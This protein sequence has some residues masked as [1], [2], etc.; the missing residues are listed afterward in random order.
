MNLIGRAFQFLQVA[1]GRVFAK[2]AHYAERYGARGRSQSLDFRRNAKTIF[3]GELPKKYQGLVDLIPGDRVVEVG[4]G[5]GVLSMELSAHKKA[6][7]AIDYTPMRHTKGQ[8][9]KAAWEAL[10][11]DVSRCELVLGDVF[12]H[13]ELLDGFD[14]LLACRVIY[15]FGDRIN[16]FMEMVSSRMNYICLIGNGRRSRRYERGHV[17]ADLGEGAY[18][19]TP[20]GMR[21]ILEKY[22]YDITFE[23]SEGDPVVIGKRKVQL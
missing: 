22:G 11:K 15:Y 4:A 8:E 19:S 10:G 18:L 3:R 14:T 16:P 21:E 20:K 13:P 9:I 6:V 5:E 17:S 23:R 1:I 2:P 12:D 7:R